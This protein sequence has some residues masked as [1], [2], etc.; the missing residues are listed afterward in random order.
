LA[1]E[2]GAIATDYLGVN[3][4]QVCQASVQL[5]HS[6]DAAQTEEGLR[7]MLKGE[8]SEFTLEYPCELPSETRWFRLRAS[9][10]SGGRHGVV[11]SHHDIS[12]ARQS[13]ETVKRGMEALRLSERRFKALFEQAAMGVALADLATKHFVQVNR[14]YCEITGYSQQEL[15]RLTFD[16]ITHSEDVA[17]D[18]KMAGELKAGVI[19]EYT[20][21][22]RYLRKD[23]TEI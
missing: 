17:Y 5:S 7:A 8:Q 3:Y 12:E 11:V 16:A 9:P 23:H 10:L 6:A 2:N 22:R 19:R 1:R 4:L 15:E 20:R 14:R 21:E 18:L 13:V